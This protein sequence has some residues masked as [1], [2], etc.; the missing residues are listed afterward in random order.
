MLKAFRLLMYYPLYSLIGGLILLFTI[1]IN[2]ILIRNSSEWTIPVLIISISGWVYFFTSIHPQSRLQG[3]LIYRVP[4]SI[5]P[6][7]TDSKTVYITFDDGPN[8]IFT[9]QLLKILSDN[10]VRATFFLIGENILRT[11]AI[12]KEIIENGHSI[13]NHSFDHSA[14]IFRSGSFIKRQIEMCEGEIIRA[15]GTKP[16]LFRFP[17]GFRDFRSIRIVRGLGYKIVSWSVMPGDWLGVSCDEIAG[18]ILSNTKDGDI[19]LLHDS[20]LV[21]Q[22]PDRRET[23]KAMPLII[24]GLKDKGFVFKPLGD[25][26][27]DDR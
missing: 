3:R 25:V 24:N 22:M 4:L 17:H 14:F 21:N 10:G 5:N 13:G 11:P 9:P 6:E 7:N 18:Y 1:F 20:D 8:I 27:K 15:G 26:I 19:I 2:Y 12:I 16:Y 23:I